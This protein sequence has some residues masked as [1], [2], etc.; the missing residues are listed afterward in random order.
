MTATCDAVVIGA[1]VIGAAIGLELARTGR[2]VV[3]VERLPAAGYGSTGSSSAVIRVH[4]STLDGTALAYDGYF[5]WKRWAEHLDVA[6]HCGLAE[7]RECGCLV[8]KTAQNGGLARVVETVG[9]LGIP[10]EHWDAERIRRALPMYD[11]ARYW[12]PRQ[13]DHPAFGEATGGSIE[14]AVFFPTAGYVTDPQLAARNLQSA[15]EAAGGRFLFNRT[16]VAIPVDGGRVNGVVLDDGTS[17]A[18]PVVVNAAGPHSG[19][20]NS[21]A[22]ADADMAVAT[23]PVRQEVAVVAPPPGID[24]EGGGTIVSDGDIGCYAR[25]E[26]GNR[27][28]IGSESPDC[29]PLEVVDPDRFSRDLTDQALAQVLRYAQRVPTLPVPPRP[30]GIVDLYDVSDDWIP[31]YDRSC[32]DG[33][34]MAIGT[35]GNQFKTAPVVGRLMARLI[36]HVEAG[37]DHDAAAMPFR[38]RHVAHTVDTATFSRRRI[39]HRDS[40]FS[41]LG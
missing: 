7:F 25:P 18:A 13:P 9:R 27:I 33:F 36:E 10:V 4:Y 8:M 29:D 11:L 22:G 15:A 16:V 39:I 6:D 1:G 35:S 23:R 12:P 30:G 20:I 26:S 31:I 37:G 32:V 19:R 17:I 14:G 24:F 34:F 41:V 3:N 28:L 21:M 38:L 40:S 5:H 2:K